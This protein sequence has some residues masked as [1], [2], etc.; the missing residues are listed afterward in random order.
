MKHFTHLLTAVSALLALHMYNT[1]TATTLA[2][3]AVSRTPPM[4][5][6]I[7]APTA[8]PIAVLEES[9]A[10]MYEDEREGR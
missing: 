2:M 9:I 10:I 5:L 4:K 3:T 8:A 6:P 7:A 1:A